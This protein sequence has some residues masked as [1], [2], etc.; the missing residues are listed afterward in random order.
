MS[1][2]S[3]GHG[4]LQALTVA[5]AV[6][7]ERER[8]LGGVGRR[9]GPKV[10]R[11]RMA[12]LIRDPPDA[13]LGMRVD[14]LLARAQRWSWGKAEQLLDEEGIT[15]TRLLGE[16]SERQRLAIARRLER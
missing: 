10:P 2:S 4:P 7:R 12:E 1:T 9:R 11:S 5:N 8:L 15:G 16:L 3:T 6:K 13:L 14:Q